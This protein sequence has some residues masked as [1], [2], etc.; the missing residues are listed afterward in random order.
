[1]ESLKEFLKPELIWFLIGLI[2]LLSEFAAPGLVIFFFGIGAWLVA[3]VCFLADISLNLQLMLFL[4]S[5]F[6]FLVLFRKKLKSLFYGRTAGFENI[7]GDFDDYTGQKVKVTKEITLDGKGKIE[8]HGTNWEA[9]AD[10]PIP[11][12]ATVMIV[13]KNN[14]TFKVIPI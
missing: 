11:E 3:L 4:V 12:G 14:I 9:E 10:V 1:M 13:E 6:L 2:L 7:E 8:F 5:S